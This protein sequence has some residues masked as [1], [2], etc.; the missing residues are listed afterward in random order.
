MSVLENFEGPYRFRRTKLSQRVSNV[1]RASVDAKKGGTQF[2]A[3]LLPV[4]LAYAA[5]TAADQLYW[6]D[7][8]T[9][10][11]W[12]ADLDGSNR[13]VV[14]SNIPEISGIAMDS[15]DAKVY[16]SNNGFGSIERADLSGSNIEALVNGTQ[17]WDIA[18]DARGGK[19]YWADPAQRK[20]RRSDLNGSN[21]ENLLTN[22][23]GLI[24]PVGIALDLEHGKMYWSDTGTDKIRRADLDGSNIED[25]V[26]NVN[27]WDVEVSG[28][29]IYW[30]DSIA[31][32]IQCANLDGSNVVDVITSSDGLS[33]PQA[34]AV[35]QGTGKLY[36]IDSGTVKIQRANVNG[37]NIQDLVTSEQGLSN[38]L[39]ISLDLALSVDF[40]ML[41]NGDGSR[42]SPFNNSTDGVEMAIP[43]RMILIAPG[44]SDETFVGDNV[45]TKKL[46]LLN[47]NPAGGSVFIGVNARELPDTGDT[48]GFISEGAQR[49]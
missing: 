34:V 40:S 48:G 16:W 26:T 30:T 22:I 27:A 41:I 38:P 36:W 11:I 28:N 17:G 14:V 43:T 23:D 10:E 29:K 13:E 45:I 46:K 3:I 9:K 37:T 49:K 39:G 31:T 32:K 1:Q 8:D 18:L 47:S 5:T 24:F 33:I 42:T 35:D 12:R 21:S 6:T 2:L 4:I 20:V 25:I 19:V 44:I 15:V 7:S